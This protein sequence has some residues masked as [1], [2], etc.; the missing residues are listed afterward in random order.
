[1]EIHIVILCE[2]HKKEKTKLP[3]CYNLVIYNGKEVYN[4][5]K[6]FVG[7]IYRFNDS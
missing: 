2:R 5:P 6:E 4:A 3:L 1:M 7:F